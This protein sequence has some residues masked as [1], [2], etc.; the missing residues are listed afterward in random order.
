MALELTVGVA[1]EL[2]VSWLLNGNPGSIEGNPAWS[3]TPPGNGA[4][5]PLLNGNVSVTLTVP[6]D[7]QIKAVGD[8]IQGEAV[9]ALEAVETL[10]AIVP[11]V[12]TA[13]SGIISAAVQ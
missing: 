7:A 3:L 13:D 2:T 4:L 9:G 12:L 8:N 5:E 6:G 11:Q 1:Q 10:T